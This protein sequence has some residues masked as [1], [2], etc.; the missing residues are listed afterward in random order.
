M[1]DMGT[2]ISSRISVLSSEHNSTNSPYSL[3]CNRR[4]TISPINGVDKKQTKKL[5]YVRNFFF[6]TR[7]LLLLGQGLPIIEASRSHSDTPH[8]VGIL[9]TSD[10]PD[11]DTSTGQHTILTIDRYPCPGRDSNP[12]SQQASGRRPTP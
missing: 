12:Q 10:R 6:V 9:W 3:M 1:T 4:H 7:R 2:G 8:L 5:R 11:A